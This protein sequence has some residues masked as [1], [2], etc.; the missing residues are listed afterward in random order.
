[1][2]VLWV[3][4]GAGWV[5]GVLLWGVGGWAWWILVVLVEVWLMR[6][7]CDGTGTAGMVEDRLDI[8]FMS[9]LLGF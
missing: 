9:I 8:F 6:D 5:L 4:G 3:V 2:G 1:M 7:T